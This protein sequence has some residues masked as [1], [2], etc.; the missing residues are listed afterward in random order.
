MDTSR[1]ETNKHLRTFPFQRNHFLSK[2]S[3]I[4]RAR[5][6][7]LPQNHRLWGDVLVFGCRAEV[8]TIV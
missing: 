3:R 7:L 8:L 2:Y 6:V 1:L 5:W 4:G